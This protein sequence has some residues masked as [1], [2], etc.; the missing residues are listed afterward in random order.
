MLINYLK[1]TS[2]KGFT[3]AICEGSEQVVSIRRYINDYLKREEERE[4]EKHGN[5]AAS[6]RRGSDGRAELGSALT[7]PPPPTGHC[8]SGPVMA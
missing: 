2:L 7:L 8:P 3:R 1:R 5:G 6:V 4:R